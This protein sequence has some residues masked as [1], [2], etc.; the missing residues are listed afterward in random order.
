MPPK[1]A[2]KK[3]NVDCGVCCKHILEGREEALQ[4]EGGC[5]L[6]FHRYC[7]G[8]PK[9]HFDEL[10]NSPAPFICLICYQRFQKVVT[11]QLQ[12]EIASLK[13][14]IDNLHNKISTE[15]KAEKKVPTWSSV[16][17]K[18]RPRK[19]RPAMTARSNDGT[20]DASNRSKQSSESSISDLKANPKTKVPVAGARKVWGTM[21]ET[22]TAALSNTLK[23]LT[24]VSDQLQIKRKYKSNSVKNRWWFVLRGGEDLL[25][26]LESEWENVQLQTKWKLEPLLKFS[27]STDEVGH[28]DNDNEIGK[29]NDNVNESPS[30]DPS[31]P[32]EQVE[33]SQSAAQPSYNSSTFLEERDNVPS[34]QI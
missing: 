13:A 3:S 15:Q 2:D 20:S 22:T 8:V 24:S 17:K 11:N 14:E 4:C 16:V 12:N 34:T 27:E 5:G 28:N 1:K 32:T 31:V 29:E 33:E 21:K 9:A 7:A 6:W 26:K 25:T 18:K 30:C 19:D 23:K 10:S